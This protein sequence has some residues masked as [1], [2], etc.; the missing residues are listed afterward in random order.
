MVQPRTHVAAWGVLDGELR[1]EVRIDVDAEGCIVAVGTRS[2]LASRPM[3]DVVR[4]HGPMMLLPGFVNAHSHAFQ[5]AIRGAAHARSQH[6]PSSFWSWREAM[7]QC[8]TS[9]EPEDVYAVTRRAY[10]EMV[11]AGITCVGEFHY[12]HHRAD[13]RPYDDPNELSLQ[14]AAAAADVGIRLVLLE[15]HYAR[16][17]QGQPP[18]PEQRRFCDGSVEAYLS[19]VDA[20]RSR[21]LQVG[22]APHSVR[23][24]PRSHLEPLVAYAHRHNLPIHMHVSEQPRENEECAREHGMSP[25]QLLSEV[26]AMDRTEGLT[27]VHAIHIDDDDRRRLTTQT[28][29]A[30]PTTEADLGDGIVGARALTEAGVGLALGSDSNAVIDLIQEARLLE[31][32][33]RLQSQARL[34][35]N[36]ER[37]RL[38]LSLLEMATLGGAR[39]LGCADRLGFFDVGRLF[40][41][42]L[43]DLRHPF[44]QGLAPAHALDAVFASGTGEVVRR[45]IV[46]GR[47][48]EPRRSGVGED[49][50]A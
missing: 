20:L 17:G 48:L 45:T 38:G 6:D 42:A 34:R 41:A 30:C 12:L 7:Y 40:D 23:A 13:G 28:V 26:G 8:A 4:D 21:G 49:R 31:M 35:L 19:R 46:G 9:L 33:E 36:D 10:A 11:A 15:V 1:P 29:C 18:L 24:V 39:A 27:A 22:I 50:G 37:G 44:L 2:D 43:V 16:A 47:E 3:F 5:R 14:V 25:V 32:H